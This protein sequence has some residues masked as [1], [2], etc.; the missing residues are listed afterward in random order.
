MTFVVKMIINKAKKLYSKD[1]YKK[2]NEE[3]LKYLNKLETENEDIPKAMK[4]HTDLCIF[5]AIAVYNTLIN[6]NMDKEE[7]VDLISKFFTK[8]SGDGFKVVSLWLH[9]FGNY[10]RYPANFVKNSLRDFSPEAGFKYK[11][12]K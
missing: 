10:H 7:A 12:S 2:M 11:L 5:P 3:A 1:E 8:L 6:H 9:M 4:K